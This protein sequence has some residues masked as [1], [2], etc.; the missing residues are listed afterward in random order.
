MA[1]KLTGE[2]YD[3]LRNEFLE[4]MLLDRVQRGANNLPKSEA[5]WARRNGLTARTL[6]GWK[7][8]PDFIER[9]EKRRGEAAQR[10]L[11]PEGSALGARVFAV[12]DNSDESD[13]AQIKSRLIAMAASGDKTAID[14]YFKTYGKSFVEEETAARKSDFR[15]LDTDELINRALSL[16]E[17]ERLIFEVESRRAV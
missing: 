15:D 8:R 4:W 9:L 10:I 1:A 11:T 6:H 3:K 17:D 12:H 7:N 14:T 16:I 13:Y 2:D 5:E